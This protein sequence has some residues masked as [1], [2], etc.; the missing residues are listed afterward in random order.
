MK[1]AII[2]L[3]AVLVGTC[4]RS[5]GTLEEVLESGELRIITRNDPTTYFRGADG[6]E[7][8]EYLLV[9]GFAK[10]IGEKY[11]RK[12]QTT[13]TTKERFT[14]V[15]PALESG[16]AHIA[17]AGLTITDERQELVAFGPSY[18]DVKQHLIY[19]LNSG[20]PR[21]VADLRGKRLEI[22]AGS[23]YAQTLA[24]LQADHP[25]FAW[26]ENPNAEIS[27][28]LGAVQ[29]KLIDYTVAD[30]T[31]YAVHR[32]YMPDLRVARDLKTGDKLAWAFRKHGS[33][34]IRAEADEYFAAIKQSGQLAQIKERYYGHT[35][36]FDYVGTRTFIRHFD[37]R[38]ENFRPMFESAGE[39]TGIDWRILAAIGYQESHWNPDAVSPTGVRGLMMLTRT[40]ARVMGVA[41]R[42]DPAESI[43]AGAEYFSQLKQRLKD[44]PE[45]D[46]TWFAL[47]AYNVGY[48]HLKDARKI[49]RMDDKNPNRW[50]D[51]KK[52]LPLLAQR[53]WYTQVPNGYARGWEPVRY[54]NNIRTYYEILNWLTLD[55]GYDEAPEENNLP[56]LQAAREESEQIPI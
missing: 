45:P 43:P 21:S 36:H 2:I 27:E 49:T 29:N 41:D 19:R 23:S 26:S 35:N 25:D 14:E 53:Q 17:A 9:E 46:R 10:Y 13:Y 51:V 34:E 15:L 18:Q 48:S 47:A 50:L 5:P 56:P 31:A 40:T 6:F 52:S 12:I 30:T 8:P 39:A 22:M 38:F 32:Y 42:E 3:L 55:E 28:L 44:I 1:N 37:T 4:S 7:G 16:E 20:M 54:V 11:D 24:K 33:D